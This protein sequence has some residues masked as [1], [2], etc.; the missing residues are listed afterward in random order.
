[1]RVSR[2]EDLQHISVNDHIVTLIY[3]TATCIVS[4]GLVGNIYLQ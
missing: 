1:M 2:T 4:G 3:F